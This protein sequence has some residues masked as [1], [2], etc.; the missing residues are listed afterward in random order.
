MQRNVRGGRRLSTARAFL[1][2]AMARGKLTVITE[3]FVTKV[4]MEGK[5][6]I[7]VA[8]SRGGRG[9]AP[10]EVQAGREVILSGGTVNLPQL[11]Q[12][13]GIGPA[14]LLS[15]LGI[16]IVHHLQGVGENFR[17][18]IA[19]R[20][21]VRVKGIETLNELAH[22]PRLGWEVLRCLVGAKSIVG[23]NSSIVYG[24]WHSDP[25]AKTNDLQFM[26]TP[27]SF[28]PFRHGALAD[29]PDYSPAAWQHRPESDGY[30]RVRSDD[31]F[32]TPSIQPNYLMHEADQRA[33]VAA[34][35]L[36]RSLTKTRA[37]A[38][39]HDGEEQPGEKVQTDD[40]LLHVA[41]K[42]G[43][44]TYHLMGTCRMSPVNDPTAVVDDELRVHGIESLCVVDA[45]I[46]RRMTS[47]NLAAGTMMIAE[48]ASDMILGE[49]ALEPIKKTSAQFGIPAGSLI[50]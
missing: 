36:A 35:R 25:A 49:P 21:V 1:R 9:G 29:W 22:G 40:E 14:G 18:H 43:A 37:M 12:L 4:L 50:S 33:A 42:T 5:K 11:L 34:M 19:P 44:S 46:M 7:G 13:S 15:D 3:A 23:L 31:P 16:E 47:A 28:D 48:K 2:P 17:D 30:I 32:E 20:F 38:P 45:S 26:F 24:F 27:A 10:M 41:C 6:A 39:Y 8:Y